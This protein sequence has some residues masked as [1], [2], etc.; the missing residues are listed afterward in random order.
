MVYAETVRGAVLGVTLA[1][2]AVALV[3]AFFGWIAYDWEGRQ[4]RLV[5]VQ[6]T[7]IATPAGYAGTKI[8]FAYYYTKSE[9]R[10]RVEVLLPNG[11][12]GDAGFEVDVFEADKAFPLWAIHSDPNS[13]SDT[14][15]GTI[16]MFAS[17]YFADV[18]GDS[19]ANADYGA[20][21]AMYLTNNKADQGKWQLFLQSATAMTDVQVALGNDQCYIFNPDTNV[22]ESYY[23][24]ELNARLFLATDRNTWNTY[25]DKAPR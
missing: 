10:L 15:Y 14:G 16:N 5:H 4:E 7:V 21:T 2:T 8:R 18:I 19:T 3:G 11:Y 17:G 24:G 20:P 6:D 1:L 12:D 23:V 22:C 13:P 9:A 25:Y